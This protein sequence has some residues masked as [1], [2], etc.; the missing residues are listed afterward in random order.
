MFQKIGLNNLTGNVMV[1]IVDKKRSIG[2]AAREV[3][4]PEHVLRFWEKE[5]SDYIQPVIG[6]GKRRYYYDNDIAILLTIKKYLYEKGYTIKGLNNLFRN[7]EVDL[8]S[9]RN[10]QENFEEVTVRRTPP[11]VGSGTV[12]RSV[13]RGNIRYD[14][15]SLK[16]K[17]N[18]FYEKLKEV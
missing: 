3:G 8:R 18:K 13:I 6:S 11:A 14:L 9:E 4:V 15:K 16:L 5:F 12:D 2:E 7:N 17:L 10:L 1:L